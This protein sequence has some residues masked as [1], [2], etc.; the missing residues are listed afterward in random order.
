MSLIIPANSLAG[1]GYAV[2]N[3]L[4]FDDGSSDYLNRTFGTSTNEKIWTF[5][6]WFKANDGGSQQHIMYASGAGS[7]DNWFQLQYYNSSTIRL[8]GYNTAWL[9]T[10][11][12]YRDRSSWYH[13]VLVANSTEATASNRLK[14]YVNGEQ[15]SSFSTDNRSSIVLNQ[16]W[17]INKNSVAH[18]IGSEGGGG[19]YLNGYLSESYFIDGQALTPTDFG[20]FD[21][22]SGIW[23]PIAYSGTYGTNGF[24]LEFQSSGALGTDSSGNANTFTVNNLTSIDQTT[25][26]PTNNFATLNPL[27]DVNAVGTYSEGNLVFTGTGSTNFG[28]C[29]IPVSN[30]KW[31]CEVK[32]TV[33]GSYPILGVIDAQSYKRRDGTYFVGS[34]INANNPSGFAVFSNGDIYHNNSSSY[35]AL[36]TTYT[37]GNIIGMAL[38][39][40]SGTKTLGFYKN[41]TLETTINLDE[42]PSGAYMFA[43]SIHSSAS[44]GKTEWNFGNPPFTI[45]TGNADANGYGNFEYAVPT[46]YLSLC[47]KNLSEVNS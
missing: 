20:E 17:G 18:Y 22:D 2:D 45:T 16:T 34:D 7:D 43:T 6:T 4:R 26:T 29:S 27:L 38:D 11:A 46:G 35:G 12:K 25:D 24:F 47:T 9:E 39:M 14:L 36:G 5:S 41:G 44:S 19:G 10:S 21:A 33:N 28:G 37:T 32:M 30:G 8:S 42:P 40:D 15:V 1:G 3:S 31:F 13:V 23:K